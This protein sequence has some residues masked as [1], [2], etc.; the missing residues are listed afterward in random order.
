MGVVLYKF[1]LHHEKEQAAKQAVALEDDETEF[2]QEKRGILKDK[3]D[4]D[5]HANG[6]KDDD[7]DA[8]NGS[9]EGIE[10][11]QKKSGPLMS[12]GSSGVK[13]TELLV[14]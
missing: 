12:R 1:T 14:I 13:D 6:Y 11:P 9:P 8:W 3:S 7:S 4:K 10:M 2:A 5:V